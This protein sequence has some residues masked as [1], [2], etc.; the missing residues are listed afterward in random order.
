MKLSALIENIPGAAFS[1]TDPE[2][3]ALAYDSREVTPGALFVALRGAA[4]DG[5][6]FIAQALNKGAAALMIHADRASWYGAHGL[7][8]VT[9]PATRDILP[10]LASTFYGDPSRRLDLI[11]VTGTNGKTTT[12]YMI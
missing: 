8:L 12:A 11:G 6:D 4:S 7:P 2:I 5:H 10:A 9:V 1:G 3:T